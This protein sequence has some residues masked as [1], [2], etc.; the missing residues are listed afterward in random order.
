MAEKAL[1]KAA[2]IH[3]NQPTVRIMP[4]LGSEKVIFKKHDDFLQKKKKKTDD[5]EGA[6]PLF[7]LSCVT[8]SS[9]L[10]LSCYLNLLSLFQTR[11]GW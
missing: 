10:Y 6:L 4:L 1:S 7:V 11:F 9:I 2:E 8:L 5:D 3:P